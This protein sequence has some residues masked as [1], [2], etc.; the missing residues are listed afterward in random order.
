MS[1]IVFVFATI[2]AKSDKIGEV[3]T[4]LKSLLAPTRAEVGCLSYVLHRH[5]KDADTYVFHE[6]WETMGDLEN[7]FKTKH[8]V[9]AVQKLEPLCTTLSINPTEQLSY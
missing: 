6:Q 1:D 2:V 3:E 4:I 8:F 9:Y 5:R 7:H